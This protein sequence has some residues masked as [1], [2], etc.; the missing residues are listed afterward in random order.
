VRARRKALPISGAIIGLTIPKPKSTGSRRTPYVFKT[1][2]F[3]HCCGGKT[4]SS[5]LTLMNMK[6]KDAPEGPTAE[7][8]GNSRLSKILL[9]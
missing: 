5:Y 1:A 2:A 8:T 6:K 3:Y 4:N 9:L 7:P